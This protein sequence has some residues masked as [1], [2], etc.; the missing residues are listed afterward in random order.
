MT[1]VLLE[2]L[3]GVNDKMEMKLARAFL[4]AFDP[5]DQGKIL[6]ADWREARRFAERVPRS[7]RSR[8]FADCLIKAIANRLRHDVR[9]FDRG[10]PR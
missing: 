8:D 10:M 4:K 7:G 3:C 1:P 9:S 6:D 2:F 5:I